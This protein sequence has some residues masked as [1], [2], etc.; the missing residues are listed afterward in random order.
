[1]PNKTYTSPCSHTMLYPDK[2]A[3]PL[4]NKKKVTFRYHNPNTDEETLKYI[5]KIFTEANKEK[6][7]Q[8]ILE[9]A[10]QSEIAAA[11]ESPA[12]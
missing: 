10:K 4:E 6:F 7:E 2:G 8:A 3:I 1:M 5:V 12:V 9:N 11:V